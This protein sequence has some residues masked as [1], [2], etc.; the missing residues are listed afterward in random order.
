MTSAGRMM[1]R[2]CTIRYFAPGPA[3]AQNNPSDTYTEVTTRCALQQR[4]RQE[5]D[6]SGQL[7]VTTWQLIL[8]PTELPP[9]SV[10]EVVVEGATYHFRGDSWPAHN[11]RGALDHI[12]GTV[13]R[14]E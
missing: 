9:H 14:A 11:T 7:S 10:D 1:T 12:E 8:G 6:E 4:G 3:D 5:V 13:V 2:S